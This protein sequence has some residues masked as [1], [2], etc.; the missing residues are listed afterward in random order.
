MTKKEQV[1]MGKTFARGIYW[2]AGMGSLMV[3][4]Y[5]SNQY[6]VAPWEPFLYFCYACLFFALAHAKK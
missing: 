3:S 4:Q 1:E 6:Q 5:L 2:L